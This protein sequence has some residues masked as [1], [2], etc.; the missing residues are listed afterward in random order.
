MFTGNYYDFKERYHLDG[1]LL[2][3]LKDNVYLIDGDVYWSGRR[4]DNYK[5]NVVLAIK[6]H[7][8]IEVSCEKQKEFDNLAIYKVRQIEEN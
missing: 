7:Y 4:Y 6:E 2:D 5:E 8:N 3:V 1:N